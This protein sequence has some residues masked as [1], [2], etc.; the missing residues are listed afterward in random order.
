MAPG[1]TDMASAGSSSAFNVGIAS[2]S[3]LGGTLLTHAGVGS[4]AAVS[5]GL[6][7]AALAGM[8]LE[9]RLAAPGRGVRAVAHA[10]AAEKGKS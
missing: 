7:V 8:V 5:A 6:A 1:S 4:L 9:P 3:L 10:A 2:G